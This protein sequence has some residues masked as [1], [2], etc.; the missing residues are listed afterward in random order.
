MEVLIELVVA[1]LLQ[2]F[3]ITRLINLEG[4]AAMWAIDILHFF[5]SKK[6]SLADT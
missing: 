3:C 6:P 1:H 4:F 5:H 2:N